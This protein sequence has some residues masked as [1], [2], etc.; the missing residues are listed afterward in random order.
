M[1]APMAEDLARAHTVVVPDLRGLGLSSKPV[2]G[3]NKKT[4]ARD[5]AG[6]LVR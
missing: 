5:V 6:V 3:F 2:G 1:W 4:Q